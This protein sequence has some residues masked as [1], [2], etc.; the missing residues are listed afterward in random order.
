MTILEERADDGRP[1]GKEESAS[2]RPHCTAG[3]GAGRAV[4]GADGGKHPGDCSPV[5]LR[6]R[7][8]L[9]VMGTFL[10]V[11]SASAVSGRDPW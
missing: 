1:L 5:L 4:S 3:A 11:V 9:H 8:L 7:S 2:R 6:P 10:T